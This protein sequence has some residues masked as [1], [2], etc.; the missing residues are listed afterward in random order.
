[1]SAASIAGSFAVRIGLGLC[2]RGRPPPCRRLCRK[3]AYLG[4]LHGLPNPAPA[5]VHVAARASGYGDCMMQV[6]SL[7]AI[8]LNIPS[9]NARAARPG[10][11]CPNRSSLAVIR[12]AH[13]TSEK[14]WLARPQ[15]PCSSSFGKAPGTMNST[16]TSASCSPLNPI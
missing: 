4:V 9:T 11:A 15:V 13:E 8:R 12:K 14:R 3:R 10:H 5:P 1:M 6:T 16:C 7:R 2:V